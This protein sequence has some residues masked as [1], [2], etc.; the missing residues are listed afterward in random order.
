VVRDTRRKQRVRRWLGQ[1]RRA[2][3]AQALASSHL[4]PVEELERRQARETVYRALDRLG[5][6][7]RRV[8]IL[9]EMEEMSGEEIAAL[10]GLKVATVW[11]HLHRGRAQFLA[12]LRREDG[13][14]P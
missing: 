1:T 10:T 9:F 8:L 3:V 11:V 4:T 2:D 13:G 7:Y 6:K 12:E 5:E 14:C